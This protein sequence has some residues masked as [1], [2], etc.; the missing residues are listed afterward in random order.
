MMI[1]AHPVYA[2]VVH[3]WVKTKGCPPSFPKLFPGDILGGHPI[4]DPLCKNKPGEHPLPMF[5]GVKSPLWPRLTHFPNHGYLGRSGG[6]NRGKK[7]VCKKQ[8]QYNPMD[9]R[10]VALKKA[11]TAYRCA[12][13]DRVLSGEESWDNQRCR[14]KQ[15]HDF[16]SGL[17]PFRPMKP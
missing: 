15:C 12:W 14:N 11:D 8:K 13:K 1:T 16:A 4:G 3:P 17:F 5:W 7:C 9:V 6:T 2:S 10:H